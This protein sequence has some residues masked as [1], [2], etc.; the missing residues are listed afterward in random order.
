MHLGSLLGFLAII[1]SLYILWRIQEVVLLGFAAVIFA[2]VINRMV[3]FLQRFRLKRGFAV[4]IS[5]VSIVVVAAGLLALTAP[6]IITQFDELIDRIPEA[7]DQLTSWTGWIQRRLPQPIAT[8]L[9][10]L[11]SL[12]QNLQ[13][14][15]SQFFSNFF[16]IFFSTLGMMLNVLLFVFVTLMLLANPQPYRRGFTLLFPSFYRDRVDEVL[17]QCEDALTGWA[18]G[19]LFNM[20]VI[21]TMSGIGLWILGVPLPLA[22]AILAALL[23]FIP[24]IGPT[25]SV[26]PPT[27]LALLENPWKAI[28]V[29]VLYIVIQ[30]VESNIL[31]PLV[32]QR[33]V[34]LLP[35]ITL[36][37]L[38]AFGLLFGILGVFLALPI[39]VVAQVWIDEVLIKDILNPWQKPKPSGPSD[40]NSHHQP[41]RDRTSPP[42]EPQE[43]QK[44]QA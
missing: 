42:S 9:R 35:A 27:L 4:F 19:M 38:A 13:A 23:T 31:T 11:D 33:Q 15:I 29:I 2:T 39:V 26:I 18:I 21:G 25:I 30:Q 12:L 37:A 41:T 20:M 14:W 8:E 3:R 24:N 1:T 32:M 10:N 7:V 5:L 40:N 43:P 17:D 28:A 16:S 36:L 22:N 44:S 6:S 34:S